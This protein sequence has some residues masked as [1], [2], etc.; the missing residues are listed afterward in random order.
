MRLLTTLLLLGSMTA[1]FAAPTGETLSPPFISHA[2]KVK[3]KQETSKYLHSLFDLYWDWRM[4]ENPEEASYLGYPGQHDKWSDLSVEA[5]ERR[6][7]FTQQILETL[8]SMPMKDLKGKERVSYRIFKRILEE[9]LA[10]MQ[11]K[12]YYLLINQM[13]GIHLS[14]PLVIALMPAKSEED[15]HNVLSRLRLLPQLYEQIT[16]LLEKGMKAGITPPAVAI[17]VVPEQILNQIPPE[18]SESSLLKA[19]Y[20]FP[21]TID[22]AKQKEFLQE[23]EAIYQQLVVPA[24]NQFHTF[25]TQRYLPNCRQTIAFSDLPKGKEWYA[26]LVRCSTTTTLTPEEIHAI[27]LKEVR[28]IQQEMLTLVKTSGFTGSFA[29]FLQFL[30]SDPQFFFTSREELLKGYQTLSHQIE[31]KLPQLFS[32]LPALPFEVIPVPSYAEKSQGVA[33]YSHGSLADNRP[34]YFF[35]N[36]SYF[37][38]RPKWEMIPLALHEAVPGH[39]LQLTLAQELKNIPEFRKHTNFTAYIEGWGLYAESLGSELGLYQDPYSQFGRLSYEMLRAM[40]LVV[41]TGM[42]ALGWSREQAIAFFK[43]HVGFSD[44][45][46]EVEIDRYLVAPGQAVAYKI[47]E[48]K[49]QE[50]RRLANKVLGPQFNIRDFHAEWLKHGTVPLDIAEQQIREWIRRSLKTK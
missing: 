8:I 30:K 43:Q 12:S 49:I 24:F 37:E 35:I 50:M 46:I 19:F 42:H 27:G 6:Q 3:K 48:L 13:H 20:H 41:D 22:E 11:F 33:Y 45:E 23:A 26:H 9:D 25:L 29:E 31:A 40:R 36:T 4:L 10:D 17:R 47:G 32:K 16:A 2:K 21:S 44:H 7:I 39:H 18:P 14:I 5:I 34:G 28:R 1:G 38:Q 15:Y